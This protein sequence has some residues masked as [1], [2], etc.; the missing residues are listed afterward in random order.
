[1]KD[2]DDGDDA[3]FDGALSGDNMGLTCSLF[4]RYVFSEGQDL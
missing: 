4:L 2:D 1:M 3:C